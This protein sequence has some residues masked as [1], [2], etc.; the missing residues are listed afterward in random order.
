MCSPVLTG[1]LTLQ[2]LTDGGIS[3]V[4]T[5]DQIPVTVVEHKAQVIPTSNMPFND[6]LPPW[7]DM[8][9]PARVGLIV[10]MPVLYLLS[11]FVCMVRGED[12]RC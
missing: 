2:V 1:R 7:E 5:I 10:L 3:P 11:G 4:Q 6:P 8:S 9:P 12:C